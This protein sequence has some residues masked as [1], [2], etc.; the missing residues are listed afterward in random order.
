MD[1][2]E[3]LEIENRLKGQ[4]DAY[5]E[6]AMLFTA[7][8]ARIP[9]LLNLGGRTPEMLAAELG[10]R[11]EP[12]RRFL[13]GLVTMQLCEELNDGRFVLT[14]AGQSLAVGSSSSLRQKAQVVVGQYWLPWLSLTHCLETGEPS[15]PLLFG[16]TVSEWRAAD[17]EEGDPFYRYLAK[18]E[19]AGAD[20]LMQSFDEFDAGTMA[21]IGS[22]YGGFLVPFLNAF[23]D[24]KAI[25]FDSPAVV[26]GA[27]PMFQAYGLQHRVEFIAGDVLKEIPV[28]ADISVLKGV[29]QQHDDSAARQILENCRDAL[30][31]GAKL[32][33][34]ERLMPERAADDPAAIML[35]LHLMTIYGGRARTKA[36]MESL[37]A[38]ARLAVEQLTRTYDGL[39]FIQAVAK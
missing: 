12:L 5:H 13:R 27:E 1:Y 31:P 29:L 30:K 26:E 19:M 33:V 10:L 15:F 17:K 6:A 9:D 3:Q 7:V 39:S 23:P 24:L 28:A 18:E 35:D 37:L 38:G 32:I 14:P 36:E 22:G 16:S 4:I 2:G 11:L 34:Y 25:V 21:S 20:D 8:A